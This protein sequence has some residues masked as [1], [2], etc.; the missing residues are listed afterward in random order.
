MS[1]REGIDSDGPAGWTVLELVKATA[2]LERSK[3]R[4]RP[5]VQVDMAR[6]ADMHSRGLS[7]RQMAR[8]LKVSKSTV[9]RLLK[10]L[11]GEPPPTVLGFSL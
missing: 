6:L 1:V 9:E 3:A 2:K 11:R 8:L 7:L 5:R 10:P 4:G